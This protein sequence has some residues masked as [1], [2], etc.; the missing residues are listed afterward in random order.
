[1]S[2]RIYDN[3]INPICDK[4]SSKMWTSADR[5]FNG[6]KCKRKNC[7]GYAIYEPFNHNNTNDNIFL[8]GGGLLILISLKINIHYLKDL[9]I[10]FI[11]SKNFLIIINK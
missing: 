9:E 4:C 6:P 7:D 3:G 10:L 8:N 11:V 5:N 1:M 2:G